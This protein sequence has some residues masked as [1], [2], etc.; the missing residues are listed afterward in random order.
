MSAGHF[1]PDVLIIVS[2]DPRYDTRSTKFLKTLTEA[3][4]R[5]MV[6]GVC[7]DGKNDEM[8]G[9]L[10]VSVNAKSG[11][12]FF[13]EFYQG[14]IPHALKASAK[15]VI[16]GDLFSL[17]PAILNKVRH[18]RKASSVK[19]IYDSKELYDELPSLKRKKSSFAFWNLVEKSSIRYVDSAFTVNDSIA[20]ILRRRWMLP[21]TVVRNVPDR[22]ESPPVQ[23]TFERITLAFSGGLQ[24]GRGLHNL[25]RL[26]TFLP[27][28]YQLKIIGDGLLREELEELASSL[29][30]T[31]RIHFTGRVESG[32][33]V[34]ELSMA[35][36]GIYLM[37]NSGLCHYLALP[38]KFFQFISARLPVIVPAFPEME[39]IVNGYGIGAAVDPSDLKRTAELVLEFTGDRELYNKLRENCEKAALELNWQV[40]KMRFLDA[41][42]RLI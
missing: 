29:K 30:L 6:V 25:I 42:E 5:A 36:I 7:S 34:G 18:N 4:H 28:K 8:P 12:R 38:N 32:N 22:S 17:P 3:G 1:E 26:L 14:V 33:V 40:E 2:S 31:D 15:V 13:K 41:V 21:F 35:H 23:R 9:I 11:K 16:A 10:R 27:E 37:E 19:L 39:K 20:E 24:P